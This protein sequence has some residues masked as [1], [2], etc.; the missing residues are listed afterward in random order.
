M[1]IWIDDKK[2]FNYI[3]IS[4]RLILLKMAIKYTTIS[5]ES[6]VRSSFLSNIYEVTQNY[7]DYYYES[8]E[9][10]T[11]SDTEAL[12]EILDILDSRYIKK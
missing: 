9:S 12:E 3:D 8:T 6:N 5:Y 4:G 7:V 10:S 11:E 2:R 1:D